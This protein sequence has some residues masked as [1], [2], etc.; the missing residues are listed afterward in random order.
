MAAAAV[1]LVVERHAEV[2]EPD[3]AG[4][5]D[6]VPAEIREHAAGPAKGAWLV[7][8]RRHSRRGSAISALASRAAHG[9][10]SVGRDK[11]GA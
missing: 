11:P 10:E 7:D 1:I 5:R 3:Q 6:G 9:E 2:V 4:V 8:R